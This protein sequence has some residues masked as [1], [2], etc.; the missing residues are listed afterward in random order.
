MEGFLRYQFGG[1]IHGGAYIRNFMVFDIPAMKENF[2]TIMYKL[3]Q[4][5]FGKWS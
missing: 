4:V 5:N 3:K 2:C 1:L